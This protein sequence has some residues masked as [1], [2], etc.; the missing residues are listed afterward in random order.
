MKD[1]L[2]ETQQLKYGCYDIFQSSK[3]NVYVLMFYNKIVS[4]L[5]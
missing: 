5:Q 4:F 1:V 3:S 2:T